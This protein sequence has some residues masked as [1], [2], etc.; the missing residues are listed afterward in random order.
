MD[1]SWLRKAIEHTKRSIAA[2]SESQFNDYG[3]DSL[4]AYRMEMSLRYDSLAMIEEELYLINFTRGPDAPNDRELYGSLL[5]SAFSCQKFTWP[6]DYRNHHAGET[7][8]WERAMRWIRVKVMGL[9]TEH[10]EI[11][12]DYLIRIASTHAGSPLQTCENAKL[13]ARG[14]TTEES[15]AVTELMCRRWAHSRDE[16]HKD[17]L[18]K[19]SCT[20]PDVHQPPEITFFQLANSF[21]YRLTG[22]NDGCPFV[23]HLAS[24]NVAKALREEVFVYNE[25]EDGISWPNRDSFTRNFLAV[26]DLMEIQWRIYQCTKSPK[27][28]WGYDDRR[29]ELIRKRFI[30]DAWHQEGQEDSS[31]LE[32]KGVVLINQQSA[33]G[34][35]RMNTW[36]TPGMSLKTPRL[37]F[38]DLDGS[39]EPTPTIDTW[40]SDRTPDGRFVLGGLIKGRDDDVLRFIESFG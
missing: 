28:A 9:T 38:L 19:H 4:G 22:S 8:A 1:D 17:A 15:W 16:D 13:E 14:P 12:W 27:D 7:R 11:D 32:D 24:L 37:R 18:L 20:N 10:D 35:E 31:P 29:W 21:R 3:E 36:W 6:S 26:Q 5:E 25:P 2:T 30:Y 33:I 34:E 23:F 39:E 40:I